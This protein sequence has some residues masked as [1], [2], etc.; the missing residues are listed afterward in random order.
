LLSNF[1][2]LLGLD[3]VFLFLFGARKGLGTIIDYDVLLMLCT[4]KMRLVQ[5][6]VCLGLGPSA[7]VKTICWECGEGMGWTRADGKVRFRE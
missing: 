6:C 4:T 7:G 2:P 3:F 5:Q 1:A